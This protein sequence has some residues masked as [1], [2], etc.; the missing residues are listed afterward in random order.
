MFFE[1]EKRPRVRSE[2]VVTWIGG[3]ARSWASGDSNSELDRGAQV[4]GDAGVRAVLLRDGL[5]VVPKSGRGLGLRGPVNPGPMDHDH[6]VVPPV[7]LVFVPAT[8]IFVGAT[9]TRDS[10][11]FTLSRE[12]NA[13]VTLI[14]HATTSFSSLG[15]EGWLLRTVPRTQGGAEQLTKTKKTVGKAK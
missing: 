9:R 2:V 10:P 6:E 8:H 4:V 1:K 11:L 14:E 7:V 13:G 15:V 12:A 5:P 3:G